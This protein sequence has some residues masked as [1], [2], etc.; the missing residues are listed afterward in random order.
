MKAAVWAEFFH[1]ASTD[2]EPPHADRPLKKWAIKARQ[3][4][5]LARIK[6]DDK[7]ESEAGRSCGAGMF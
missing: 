7:V 1:L 6:L 5:S 4:R 3:K 2:K